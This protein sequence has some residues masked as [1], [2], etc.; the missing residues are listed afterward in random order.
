MKPCADR[1]ARIKPREHRL[2]S[3]L[4][5]PR[6]LPYHR[7]RRD[8][9]YPVV[10]RSSRRTLEELRING[11]GCKGLRLLWLE[12]RSTRSMAVDC[13]AGSRKGE[14]Y[15]KTEL[16]T[17]DSRL[18]TIAM[19]GSDYDDDWV[20]PSADI[21]LVLVGKLGYGKSATG[22]S[23]LGREAFVSEYS[24]A[25]VT[26]TCQMG[27]TTLKDG[28]T[29][30][31]IDT[32]GLFD[33]SITSEDAGKEIVKCMNMAKDG[34]HAV[35][36]VFSATSRFSREDSST[37]E[38]IKVFFGDKIVD[39]MILVFTYGDLVGES[40]LKSM[41]SNA[42]EYLQKMV[43]L[44]KNRVV[45]FDN[46]TKDPRVQA[47]QLE[48]LLDVVDSVC[49]NNGG[50]PFSDQ[51]FTRIKEVH[52]REKEVQAMGY[53]EEQ[54]SEL[55]KEI[56][57]TR[58]EQLANITSMLKESLKKA[59]EENEE[60]R[61]MAQS[62][63]CPILNGCHRP[64]A[65]P[66]TCRAPRTN[67][68]MAAAR[69]A[70][71]AKVDRAAA[72]AP[73]R[74]EDD[75]VPGNI[76]EIELC[77]FMT[78]DRLV[79]RP[80]PRLNLVIGPNGS[81]KSSL[82]C[83]IALGLAGDPN[84]LGRASSV[85]TFVKRGEVSGHVKI[86]LRGDT[87]EDKICITRKIDTQ[88][89]SEWLLNGETVPKKEVIDVIKKFN[90]QVNNLTQFLPQDRVSEF[91]K[92]SS[93]QL[94][95]ETE[96][97]IGDP[98]L[99]IQHRQLVDTRK[100]QKALE[101]AL[102]QMEQTLNN[103]KALNAEQEKDVERVRLRNEL[104]RKAEL[105]KKKLPWRKYDILNKEFIEVIQKQEETAKKKMEEAS[106]ILEDSRKPIEGLK[107]VKETHASSINKISSQIVRNTDS[108]GGV[109]DD[110]QHLDAQLKSTFDDIEDLKRQDKSRKQRILKAKKDLAAAE[111]ELDDLPAHEP[112]GAE[113][114]QLTNQVA[115]VCFDIKG[116]KEDR[117]AKN[118]QLARAK[119][120]MHQC[121]NR[122]KDME[123]KNSKLLQALRHNTCCDKIVDAYRW[124][125][126]NR[127]HFRKEV[128]GPVLLE[129]NVQD[130]DLAT[131]LENH[132][133]NYIWKDAS[134]CD[135]LVSKMKHY[136]VPVLNYT[137][138]RG[139]RREPFNITP[140]MQQLGIFSRL[141]QVF[142]AP[143]VV[144]DILISQAALDCSYIG[145][146]ETHRRAYDV[147]KKL[148][149]D[150]SDIERLRAQIENHETSS[151]GMQ[152]ELKMLERKQ[153]QLEDE[154]ARIHKMKEGII[155]TMRSQKKNR[156]EIQR[157][158]DIKRRKLED[159]YKEEDV[160]SSKEKHVDDV[161]KLNDQ[162]FKAAM[163]LKNLLME[164]VALKWS[165]A[166][167]KMTYVEL[168]TKVWEMERGVKKLEKDAHLAVTEY[169]RCKRVTQEHKR[170]LSIAKQHAES[171]AMITKELAKEFLAMP[172]TI[173]E[174]E[175]AIQDIES[176]ANSMLFLNQN[177]LQEYQTRQHEIESISNKL[178]DDKE[179]YK[180]CCS[181][182]ETVKVIWLSTLQTLVSKIN[183]TFSRNF[184][185]MAI[186]G[187]VS[188]DEHGLDFDRYGIL[189][190]V[191]FRQT[192]QL[193]VLSAHHQSGGERSV[194]TILYLVSLQDLTNCPFRVVD[195]INQGKATDIYGTISLGSAGMD[196]INERK[197]FQQL[198]RAA[199]KLNTPQCFLLTPK[200]LPDLE[201]SDACSILNIM[202]GPWIEKPA[203]GN[204]S[205]LE[206]RGLLE[207]CDEPWWA[208]IGRKQHLQHTCKKLGV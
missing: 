110:E 106:K 6:P 15:R 191:K 48:K 61:R 165:Y 32:P 182:I 38:T 130:R 137:A 45:L 12:R 19:G 178:Q 95:E 25:S 92:L 144:K 166:E 184:Q 57:R 114:A 72:A 168:D 60:F 120:S 100:E 207:N 146:E 42:P 128:Y 2:L 155:N 152:E 83:A 40:K 162:R 196:P 69:A 193:Q 73:Q 143:S 154:E 187:E 186:A 160:E 203:K 161:T 44:C 142:E 41:L 141:D 167:K 54:I 175:A 177:V 148:D 56:H 190:K 192:S 79:C 1:W 94:L 164:A 39:H 16:D 14:E 206:R 90:I 80:G 126:D 98:D 171:V 62:K 9:P 93:I 119:E 36:M 174:L 50:K 68:P 101:V 179:A 28:R 63:K 157:R 29:I 150:I 4:P 180:R 200:L 134:D 107:K 112:R 169:G 111:K 181:K 51:M 71:R 58:D 163:R 27:S 118:S 173:E 84:V 53:S 18:S 30:N 131:Y 91:A 158:V 37:I 78:Y 208:F 129:V 52:D 102:K 136:G 133:S 43:E 183:D 81:G 194:S 153:R 99:P 3:A 135:K 34:I 86:S 47:K 88:N 172:T 13:S 87:P 113:L 11:I 204:S 138:D 140:D 104:L 195:E 97:A 149:V 205:F 201:Y 139:M 8:L 156:H 20:L 70:K 24:H 67:F 123:S 10:A 132:V 64:A 5:H 176:E 127:K 159:I 170:R 189:I 77:N 105:M 82:V 85:G 108:R 49:S 66:C 199:S 197:M 96:K 17:L 145:T 115:Q 46:M 125:Q 151:Q 75:Y 7:L 202:N 188:L 33:M 124:V 121:S 21:T 109:A 22:N 89:K 122:L 147:P 31:V 55:K 23:I 117:R 198:V 116:L 26:N 65:Q 76:V 35:L 103:L 74:G 185:E 59:Q